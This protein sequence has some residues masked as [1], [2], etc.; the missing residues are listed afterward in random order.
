MY[1]VPWSDDCSA[2]SASVFREWC[3]RVLEEQEPLSPEQEE[4]IETR[5][6][7]TYLGP[8]G[9]PAPALALPDLSGQTVDLVDFRGHPT[10]VLFWSPC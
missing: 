8:D 10:L 6:G 1:K 5:G 3:E 7:G 4:L 9:E 2:C